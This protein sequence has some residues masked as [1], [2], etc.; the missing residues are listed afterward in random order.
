LIAE[1]NEMLMLAE[2]IKKYPKGEIPA[3]YCLGK[4]HMK[5]FRNKQ[6]YLKKRHSEIIAEM[7]RRGFKARKKMVLKSSGGWKPSSK[8]LKIIKQRLCQKLRKKPNFYRYCGKKKPAGF[9]VR[10]IK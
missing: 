7:E 2:Y 5:F 3:C 9:F 6:G 10:M 4:G 1:Y 8:D